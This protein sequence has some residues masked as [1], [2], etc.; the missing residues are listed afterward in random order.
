MSGYPP[1]GWGIEPWGGGGSGGGGGL[2]PVVINVTPA[3]GTLLQPDAFIDFDVIDV[4]S[5]MR[6]IIVLVRYL[7]IATR[8]AI[9]EIPGITPQF[10]VDST[11]TPI[12]N[13]L[14]FHLRRTGGWPD[15]EIS[16][17]VDA[18][19]VGGNEN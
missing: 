16:I 10:A 5:P 18:I 12:A 1:S 15:T 19:D 9:Y 11:V 7:H 14:H 4:D 17:M 13:G 2:P 6:R 8:E 3:P